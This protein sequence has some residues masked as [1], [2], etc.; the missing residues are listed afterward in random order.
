[1]SV[2]NSHI[3][4]NL[5]KY[6]SITTSHDVE[7]ACLPANVLYTEPRVSRSL[8]TAWEQRTSE[9]EGEWRAKTLKSIYNLL[10]VGQVTPNTMGSMF[11]WRPHDV[12]LIYM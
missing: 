4:S 10:A 8:Y 7:H 6:T 2:L 5:F 3:I 9:A 12:E 11:D 1:M